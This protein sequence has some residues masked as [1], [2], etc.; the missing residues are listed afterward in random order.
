MKSVFEYGHDDIDALIADR[1]KFAEF[2]Y[3]SMDEALAE[4]KKRSKDRELDKKVIEFLRGDIPKPLLEGAKLVLARHLVTPNFEIT[5]FINIANAVDIEPLFFEY[6]DDKLIYKNPWKYHLGK[7]KFFQGAGKGGGM[8]TESREIINFD[9][10]HGK[11]ISTVKTLWGQSLV[12]FHH[13]VFLKRHP[14]LEK[15]LFDGSS[16]YDANGVEPKEFYKRFL[17]LFIKNGILFENFLLDYKEIDF[18]R[19][20]ILP[21]FFDVMLEFNLKPLIVALEPTEIEGND[22]WLF[23]PWSNET[24]VRQQSEQYKAKDIVL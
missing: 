2:L 3:T 1:K 21:A 16:W 6:H 13:Q 4:L 17:A 18:T 20:I 9:T 15:S 8:K 10:W 22:F 11:K 7:L 12:D 14:G 5:R 19:K 24:H 23:H